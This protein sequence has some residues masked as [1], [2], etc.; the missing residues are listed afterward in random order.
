[1]AWPLTHPGS[2]AIIRIKPLIIEVVHVV[3]THFLGLGG[4]VAQDVLLVA[5]EVIVV[6][7]DEFFLCAEPRRKAQS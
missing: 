7:A 4:Q 3:A 6:D 1:M 5:E 2:L